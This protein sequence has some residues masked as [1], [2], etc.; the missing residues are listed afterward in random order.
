MPSIIYIY[1]P[2]SPVRRMPKSVSMNVIEPSPWQ[3]AICR[4][5]TI[6]YADETVWCIQCEKKLK[7]AEKI[8]ITRGE[9]RNTITPEWT[10]V[11]A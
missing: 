4:G 11:K 7:D 1:P 10:P 9:Q 3:C 2:H 5:K 6:A 8:D